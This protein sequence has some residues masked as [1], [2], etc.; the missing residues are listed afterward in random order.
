M[1]TLRAMI[2]V[3]AIYIERWVLSFVFL[4]LASSEIRQIRDLSQGGGALQTSVGVSHHAILFILGLMTGL[5]LLLGRRPLV[6]PTGLRSILIPLAT[7]FFTVSYYLVPLF[8]AA[9]R[10]KLCAPGME[11]PLMIAGAIFI[12]AGPIIS[13]WGILYLRRSFG[14]FIAVRPVVLNG[15]YRWVRHPMY[16]G[17]GCVCLGVAIANFSAAYFLL[18]AIHVALLCYRAWLEEAEIAAHSVEYRN[19][20]GTTGF[21]L[22]RPVSLEFP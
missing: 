19:Y 4:I 17:W 7:T 22:P 8:P 13:L 3:A 14:V 1:R 10:M 2:A 16:L 21:I 11:G 6:A 9:M 18:T 5:L 15:P 20:M 12:M